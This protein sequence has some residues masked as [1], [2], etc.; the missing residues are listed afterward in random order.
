M[1]ASRQISD[2]R[3][4]SA[5]LGRDPL[6]VQAASGNTSVKIGSV[7]WIKASGKWLSD[8]DLDEIFVP[9]D[10]GTMSVCGSG[11]SPSIET[12]MHVVL[13]HKVVIHVHSVN[14]ISWSVRE[15]GPLHVAERLNGLAWAW[16]P[17]VPSGFPLA[18]EI[19]RGNEHSPLHRAD[20]FLL[21]NHGLVVAAD[22]C[23][24]AEAL[25]AEVERRL[26]VEPRT[27]P[28][29]NR[30][31]LEMMSRG[32]GWRVPAEPLV[33][34]LG[35]DAVSQSIFEG[36]T[37]YPC[38]GL[39]LGLGAAECD[40]CD[41]P[42]SAIETYRARYGS[43]PSTMAVRGQGLLVSDEM[44]VTQMQVLIGLTMV[45]QR[46]GAEAHVRYL[47]GCET[48]ELLSTDAYQYRQSVE[49]RAALAAL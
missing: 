17:Y 11:L 22:D 25:L 2:L 43:R 29:P 44:S 32:T 4:L 7:L 19:Q 15:D 27:A 26:H 42:A 45:I 14:A 39:F 5:K 30:P 34:A 48:A 8:A 20:V 3:N 38:H 10:I 36:G 40:S 47:T 31:H 18:R 33:H 37:L 21:A 13:P 46:I 9:V 35:T 1:T 24:S 16:I 6:L 49:A 28:A 23:E 41:T 12:A